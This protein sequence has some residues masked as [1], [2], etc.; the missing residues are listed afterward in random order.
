MLIKLLL[1]IT[2][3]STTTFASPSENYF[4]PSYMAQSVSG[5]MNKQGTINNV[6]GKLNPYLTESERTNIAGIIKKN[7]IDASAKTAM[8]QSKNNE[9][10]STGIKLV[11]LG[12]NKFSI[13]G[14]EFTVLDN[15]TLDAQF[16]SFLQ[17][18]LA[19]NR[20]SCFPFSCAHA[21]GISIPVMGII[22]LCIAAGV[23]GSGVVV[24]VS[25]EIKTALKD[26][27][28]DCQNGLFVVAR[29]TRDYVVFTD[30][31]GVPD[32]E[33][34]VASQI[35]G[36]EI[37]SCSAELAKELQAKLLKAEN[38]NL[39]QITPPAKQPAKG[40]GSSKS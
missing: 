23:I 29:K 28:V 18:N 21:F 19:E 13:N 4:S 22:Y 6:L 8:F 33:N 16:A 11:I 9:I 38:E 1:V 24:Y 20:K 15:Q 17:M 34:K 26:G 40:R 14:K 36:K 5:F 37:K 7:D 2:L 12:R 31:K 30:N 10:T 27:E 25:S 39:L 35:L 3:F 32:R